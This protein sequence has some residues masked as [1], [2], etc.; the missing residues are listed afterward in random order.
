MQSS[1]ELRGCR[2]AGASPPGT[3]ESTGAAAGGRV[4]ERE[5]VSFVG[6]MTI[7][8]GAATVEKVFKAKPGQERRFDLSQ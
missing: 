6:T 8:P 2:T 1:R 4:L 5:I 3:K 7:L